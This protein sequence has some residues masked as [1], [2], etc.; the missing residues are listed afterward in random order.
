MNLKA[1]LL[2]KIKEKLKMKM[3]KIVPGKDIKL[4]KREKSIFG[5]NIKKMRMKKKLGHKIRQTLYIFHLFKNTI[6]KIQIK[7]MEENTQN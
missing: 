4:F 5:K 2:W 6:Q 7:Q 3:E 1:L